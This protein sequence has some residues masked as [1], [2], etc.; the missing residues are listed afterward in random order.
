[1]DSEPNQRSR[2]HMT[3]ITYPDTI[4]RNTYRYVLEVDLYHPDCDTK[5]RS[6]TNVRPPA[7][8]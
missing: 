8:L 2:K 4:A 1:M 7:D 5:L 6:E 3:L